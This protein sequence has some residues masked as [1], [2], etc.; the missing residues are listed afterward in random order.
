ME[1]CARC[2]LPST[3][4]GITFNDEGVCNYC[5]H[6]KLP[7]ES[8]KNEYYLKFE[9]LLNSVKGKND[10]DVIIAFSGGKDSTYTLYKLSH[11]YNLKILAFTLD[12]GFIS[13]RA[14]NNITK[15]TDTLGATGMIVRPP[16][17]VMKK[18]FQLAA[19]KDLYNPKTLDRA[20][21]ICTTCIGMVKSM[22]LKTAI[23]MKIPLAAYGWTPGQA[24]ISSAI[25]KTNPRLQSMTHKTVRD[26]ILN[27]LKDEMRNY[28]LSDE[29]LKIDKAHWPTN[30]HPL[31]FM[32]YNEHAITEKIQ[33]LGWEKPMDT[34]PNSTNCILNALA[35]YLHREK[36]KFHPY[37]WEMAGI[38]R[39]NGMTREEAV[40]K[41]TKEEDTKMVRYAA[42]KLDINI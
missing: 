14:Y 17:N 32:N 1:I 7:D 24:P 3:F 35:N 18:A 4:P 34:D 11:D 28:F 26:P 2:V 12:N 13:E 29:D 5:L 27:H 6:T 9:E 15:M 31:A 40:E 16:F 42:E 22:V 30:I 23:Q 39:I 19:T 21:S 37:A 36:F 10:Y 25:M 8:K 41:S 33:S 38:V 20:S